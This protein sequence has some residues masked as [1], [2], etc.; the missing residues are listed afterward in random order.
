MNEQQKQ[1][2]RDYQRNRIESIRCWLQEQVLDGTSPMICYIIYWA[3]FNALYNT[4]D[5][6]YNHLPNR[7]NN[8]YR[9]TQ[10]RGHILPIICVNSDSKRIT[11]IAK[12]LADD[13]NFI[14]R[15][16][17]HRDAIIELSDHEPP[18]GQA[19]HLNRDDN[20]EITYEEGT[21]NWINGEFSIRSIRGI[22]SLDRRLFLKNDLIIYQYAPLD[23]QWNDAAQIENRDLFVEQLLFVMYQIRNNIVHGGSATFRISKKPLVNLAFPILEDIVEYFLDP[24]SEKFLLN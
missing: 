6:P 2:W 21:S 15:V 10:R 18:V 7:R 22:A 24:N 4:V 5:L 8:R 13:D 14:K 9:F 16:E 17:Q 19:N 3:V 20:I 12:R 23:N 11:L 1:Q